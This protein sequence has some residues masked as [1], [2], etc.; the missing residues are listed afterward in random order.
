MK[1]PVYINN[2][3][4][5]SVLFVTSLSSSDSVESFSQL[6]KYVQYPLLVFVQDS[7]RDSLP[8]YGDHV[9]VQSSHNYTT[10]FDRLQYAIETF[11]ECTHYCWMALSVVAAV[12]NIPCRLDASCLSDKF[13][14]SQSWE[15]IMCPK[16]LVPMIDSSNDM[17]S[18]QLLKHSQ[19]ELFDVKDEDEIF[20][21]YLNTATATNDWTCS[22]R[23]Q[24]HNIL[25]SHK[26]TYAEV[27][28]FKAEFSR[29]LLSATPCS[30]L[31]LV[32]PYL[33][34][35]EYADGINTMDMERVYETARNNVSTFTGRFHFI[36]D[37]SLKA[38]ATVE[39]GSLDFVYIDGNHAYDFVYADMEAWWPKLKQGGY[40]VCDDCYNRPLLPDGKN[41]HINWGPTDCFGVYGVYQASKD[42]AKKYSLH[43]TYFST[44][45]CFAKE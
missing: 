28:V 45:V 23:Y 13:I 25:R 12:S 17:D 44:Q 20:Q 2:E 27:G 32:D 26:G 1:V 40:M 6:V 29:Y 4:D 7:L 24:M 5:Q 39:D 38:A 35:D 34:Y 31:L 8:P 15:T 42:F 9:S 21:K 11:P 16:Q 33:N 14:C 37:T 36:R 3:R 41:S 18:L 22:D 43:P 30:K 19:P 10:V